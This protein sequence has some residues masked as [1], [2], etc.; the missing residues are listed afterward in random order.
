M[1]SMINRVYLRVYLIA[2][3]AL[4]IAAPACAQGSSTQ[5][6][7]SPSETS[8]ETSTPTQTPTQK[9]A[10]TEPLPPVEIK[11]F[12]NWRFVN[13]G[14]VQPKDDQSAGAFSQVLK[15]FVITDQQEFDE[16]NGG[17]TLL[18]SRATASSLARVEFQGSILLAAYYVWRPLQGDPLSIVGFSVEG[19]QATVEMELDEQPQGRLRPYLMAPMT[20]VAVERSLFSTPGPVEFVFQVNG[21]TA[22]TVTAVIK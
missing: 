6:A 3:L 11:A 21:K 14:W 20:V 22:A 9:P 8:T 13:S 15:A 12:P 2:A 19:N 5:A 10:A 16:F 18:R 4:L 17:F 7:P 1:A